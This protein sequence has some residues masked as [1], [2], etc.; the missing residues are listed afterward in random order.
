MS[1]PAPL[2]CVIVEDNEMNHLTL[3]HFVELTPSLTLA[4]NLSDGVAA[5]Y[6]L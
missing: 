4:A 1:E 5:L 6:Y 2:R 3:A